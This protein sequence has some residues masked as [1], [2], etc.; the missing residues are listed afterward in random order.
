MK[1]FL[2]PVDSS[3]HSKNALRYLVMMSTALKDSSYTLFYVQPTISDYL[4]EEAAGDPVAR[5]KL[6]EINK[7]NQAL[8]KQILD[9]H[10]KSFLELVEKSNRVIQRDVHNAGAKEQPGL[11][12]DENKIKTLNRP[13][14]EGVAKDILWQAQKESSDAIIIG[15]HGF[16]RLKETLIGSTSKNLI[17]HC[18]NTPVWMVD[19][20]INSKNILM[21]V[22]GSIDSAKS[23][24]YL[25]GLLN[26]NPDIGVTLFHVSPSLR[27][28][29]GIDLTELPENTDKNQAALYDIIEKANKKC[30]SNFLD[31]ALPA[32]KKSGIDENRLMVKTKATT[33]NIGSAIIQEFK[34]GNY[35]TLI[36]GKRGLNKRFFMGSVSNYL[37]THLENGAIWIIP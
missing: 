7:K 30:I 22:D 27:D 8:G 37:V 11:P 25:A 23:T 20:E 34:S 13:R 28:S 29:C 24:D 5:E 18:S 6:G 19:G 31:Y 1:N 2:I 3:L 32:L 26:N 21:A 9:T 35:G 16:S 4:K 10:K 17:E 14:Q 12:I 33:L 36:V 15:R